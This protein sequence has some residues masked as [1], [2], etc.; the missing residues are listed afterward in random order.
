MLSDFHATTRFLA[1]DDDDISEACKT[2][3]DD[4]DDENFFD[5][6]RQL[7]TDLFKRSESC[8]CL[9]NEEVSGVKLCGEGVEQRGLAHI[10]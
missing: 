4:D 6:R 8:D 1:T 5:Y 7:K 10:W 3:T 2:V 9:S